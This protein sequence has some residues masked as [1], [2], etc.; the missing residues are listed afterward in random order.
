MTTQVKK[1]LSHFWQHKTWYDILFILCGGK[2]YLDYILL[3]NEK[4]K[5]PLIKILFPKLNDWN[6]RYKSRLKFAYTAG[7]AHVLFAIFMFTIGL[8]F[9]VIIINILVNIY[10]IIVQLYIGVRCWKIIQGRKKNCLI[11]I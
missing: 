3:T 10:P 5:N 1:V 2:L 8:E 7:T 4:S 11:T 9:S 6:W